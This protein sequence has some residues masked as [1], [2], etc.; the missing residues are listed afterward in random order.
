[1]TIFLGIVGLIAIGVLY[2]YLKNEHDHLY[3]HKSFVR[4]FHGADDL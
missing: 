3:D 2:R 1:M 4:Y